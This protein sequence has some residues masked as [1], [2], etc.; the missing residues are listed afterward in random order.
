MVT[1]L[2][3]EIQVF[4]QRVKETDTYR[5]YILQRDKIDRQPDLKKKIDEFRKRNFELQNG[6]D[7]EDLF[8]KIDAFQEESEKFREDPMVDAFLTAELEFCR[9]MQKVYT[10]ISDSLGFE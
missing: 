5:N 9:M 1:E 2:D 8:D 4:V 3:K 6:D 7:S 10:T